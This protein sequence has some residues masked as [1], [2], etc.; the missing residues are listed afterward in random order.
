MYSNFLVYLKLEPYL[1]QW[2]ANKHGQFPVRFPKGSIENDIIELG[3]RPLGQDESPDLPGEDK[4]PIVLPFFR[5]KDVRFN[6]YLPQS[7]KSELIHC[8]KVQFAIE[9]WK[10]LNKFG[11]IGKQKQDLIYAWIDAHD[12]DDTEAN[13]NAIA[14]IYARK[15]EAHRRQRKRAE[16]ED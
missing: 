11:Y 14:K 15:R 7:A 3:L 2:L 5:Y 16:E 9:L 8:L 6:N 10:D 13:W 1:A 12:I 4:Y